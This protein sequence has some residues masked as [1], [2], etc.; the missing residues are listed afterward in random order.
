MGFIDL[1]ALS[2]KSFK[3]EMFF[4]ETKLADG[5]AFFAGFGKKYMLV[6]NKHN[7][8]GRNIITEEPISCHGGIP[9]KISVLIPNTVS[10]G[11]EGFVSKGLQKF[12]IPLY[13]DDDM[14]EPMWVEHLTKEVDVVGL[15]FNPTEV[16]T[17]RLILRIDETWQPLDVA[18]RV[19]IIGYPFGL[20]TDHFPIWNTGFVASE[21]S[22]DVDGFPLMYIDARTRQGQSGSP[23]IQVVNVGDTVQTENG[24]YVAK[25]KQY[26]M[27]GV[28]S[29]RVS[30]ESDIGRVWK[31]TAIRE[32][33]SIAQS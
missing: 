22:I 31:V 32:L 16:E 25:Q 29:G 7:V 27:V 3:I 23:V 30:Q 26:F 9:N 33:F 13:N 4:N 10:D 14:L 18:S 20:T 24:T 11:K 8:T 17:D 2:F 15:Q 21:P 19:N 1:N 12:T 28:Y 6:T 5:T